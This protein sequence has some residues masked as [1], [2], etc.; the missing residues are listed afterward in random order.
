MSHRIGRLLLKLLGVASAVVLAA[1][2]YVAVVMGQPQDTGESTLQEQPL[3]SE[4]P[5]TVLSELSQ[6]ES[7][8][9]DF[10]VAVL[11][12][13]G[14]GGLTLEYAAAYSTPFEDGYGRITRLIYRA[15]NDLTVQVD[16]IYPA[17]A[18]SLIEGTGYT[19]SGTTGH[20]IAGMKTVRMENGTSIRLHGQT[21]EGLYVIT[22]PKEADGS[23]AS[24]V[25]SLQLMKLE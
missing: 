4:Q 3:L 1:F 12:S 22:L 16:S 19:L 6:L 14:S 13:T 8:V 25:R 10:P 9:R 7:L 5:M 2:F 20:T 11:L 18:L 17:R 24:L 15:D 21:S 23:I